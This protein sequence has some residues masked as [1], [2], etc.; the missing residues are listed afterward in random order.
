VLTVAP[1]ITLH[2]GDLGIITDE[3]AVILRD[4]VVRGNDAVWGGGVVNRGTFT[5]NAT[6]SIRK[7]AA[8]S[9]GGG[10]A[11]NYASMVMKG[12]STIRGNTAPFAGGVFNDTGTLTMNAPS[13]VGNTATE[14]VLRVGR[15]QL[16]PQLGRR[17]VAQEAH[18]A[19]S[20]LSLL[21]RSGEAEGH[22]VPGVGQ[23]PER[24]EPS[25]SP[26]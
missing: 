15:G 6:S 18:V 7:N 5:M 4:V 14:Y 11:L 12:S 10:G 8:L 9:H 19:A 3:G 22:A 16:G 13:I 17:D 26:R 2:L 25:R 1:E 23:D 21:P 24:V 20:D